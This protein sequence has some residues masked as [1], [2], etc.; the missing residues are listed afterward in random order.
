MIQPITVDSLELRGFRAYLQPQ[1]FNFR[2]NKKPLSMAVFAPNGVGKSSLVD[3]FEYYFSEEPTLERLV[4]GL[5]LVLVPL[6]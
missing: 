5:L 2:P 1:T 4:E 6:Q 3:S